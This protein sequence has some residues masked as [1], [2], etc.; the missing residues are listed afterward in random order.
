MLLTLLSALLIGNLP[1]NALSTT[2][3]YI[4]VG[5]GT[6]GLVVANRLSEIAN[7]SVLIIEAGDSVYDNPNVTA[8]DGYGRALGSAIDRQYKTIPQTFGNQRVQT[9]SAAK[10]LGGT[11]TINGNAGWNWKALYPY[12]LKSEGY[13]APTA[14]QVTGGGA[15]FDPEYH[16]LE[17]PLRVGYP[18]DQAVNDLPSLL[19]KSYEALGIPSPQDVNGGSMRG[20][21]VYPK[22]I[23]TEANVRS[24]AAR[25]YYWPFSTSRKN[26]HLSLNSTVTKILWK[27]PSGPEQ[28]VVASAVEVVAANALRT[29][30]LLELSGIGNTQILSKANIETKVSLPGVGEHLIDQTNNGLTFSKVASEQYTGV[31]GYASYPNVTDVFGNSTS[32]FASS[33]LAAL[34]AYASAISA[35]NNNCTSTEDML[36]LLQLQ[37]SLIFDA[38]VPVA[39]VITWPT[40][41]SFGTQYWSTLPFARGNIHVTSSDP[42]TVARINPNYFM[43]AYDLDSQVQVARWMRK[44]F[45]TAP[46]ADVNYRGN[47]HVLST[48]AMMPRE[49]GGVV[50]ERLKVYGTTNVRV[51]DASVFPFQVCGHLM[52]TLTYSSGPIRQAFREAGLA[53]SERLTMADEMDVDAT[54]PSVTPPVAPRRIQAL[55]QDVVN[56]IAAGEI[57]VAPVHALKELIENAVDAGSTA[58]EVLVKD[59]GLKLLQITDNGHGIDRDD[60]PILCERFTTSKLKAF[61]DLTSIGTYGFRGEALASISHIAHLSV[62]TRVKESSCAWK[63]HYADGK[64]VP[65]KP[66]QGPDPKPC[67]G[68]QGTQITVE[69]L[70]Y[71][72]PTRRRA[73]RSASEEY[74]KI[75]D[76]VGR[77]AV[78]CVGVSFSC[79]KHGDSSMGISVPASATIVDRIRQVQGNAV[80]NELIEVHASN[81]RWGFKADAWVSNANYSVKRTTLLLFINHRSVDSSAIKKAVEQTYSTFLPKGGHPFVYLSLDIDPQ[82]VDVNVHP[83]KREV[84]FLNEDEI[85]E[86]ICDEI[87]SSLG[88]VDTSRTFMTQS[89]LPGAKVPT[90]QT[91]ATPSR[92]SATAS[93][94][95]RS[96]EPASSRRTPQQKGPTQKPREE[97][98]SFEPSHTF[99]GVVDERRRIAAIQGGVKLFLIDYAMVCNEYFYQVGLTDF[100]NFGAIRFDPALS[101]HELLSIAVT[102]EKSTAEV[103]EDFDWDDALSAVREQLISRRD[104]LAEYFSLEISEDGDLV[105]IPLLIKGYT[106]SLAKLP[107]FLLRLGPNVNWMEEKGCFRA[108]LRELASFYVPEALPVPPQNTESE[109]PEESTPIDPEIESRRKHLEH[110][111]EHVLFPAFRG[112][113]VAT[114]GLYRVFERC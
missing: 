42:S 45:S 67:A 50:D 19:S 23:D 93:S 32:A 30:S 102:H 90:I 73:F 105:S 88:N 76:L 12:Y 72:V 10:A 59:G 5:G 27:S 11:S 87:R 20:F 112:R 62:T 13:Q 113:L 3:D 29:P 82:R 14:D 15:S 8:V 69:D 75:L 80:A 91:N 1:V 100:G 79:K 103:D 96:E 84:N 60:L 36:S 53:C 22:T 101:L 48:A 55:S 77:Y 43:L 6:C 111:I 74:A 25:A 89:L 38:Q 58:L 104:M 24:D 41:K 109:Q 35:Q 99:V 94:G 17:G 64:L 97:M 51:V 85:I 68:R 107:H 37:H 57:I 110:A 61:E 63:A 31:S 34:P 26:L 44:L 52:S 81:D 65:P 18:E 49:K 46:L 114:K 2:Y 7:V 56:K 95:S 86:V 16:G 106:P 39:E 47:H 33:V 21:T 92:N 71:N 98:K 9:I 54:P 66:N 83:T 108:F 70:F 28:E 78:H 40:E 4:V